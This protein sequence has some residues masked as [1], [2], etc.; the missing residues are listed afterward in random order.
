MFSVTAGQ[1][2]SSVCVTHGLQNQVHILLQ[3]HMDYAANEDEEKENDGI[4]RF[5]EAE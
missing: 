4:R 1:G 2:N 3:S 5:V